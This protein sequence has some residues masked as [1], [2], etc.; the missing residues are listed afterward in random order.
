MLTV[1]RC[2]PDG[3]KIIESAKEFV[4]WPANGEKPASYRL[5]DESGN[6]SVTTIT[7]DESWGTIYVMNGAG[8]TVETIRL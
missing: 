1:K 2:L 7:A 5:T 6:E 8:A 4:F 3:T